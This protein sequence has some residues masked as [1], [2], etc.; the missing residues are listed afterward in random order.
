MAE[1]STY[2]Q[3]LF[4][5]LIYNEEGQP[6]E[7]TFIG[8]EPNYIILDGDFKRHVAAE[9]VDRQVINWL[10]EQATANKDLVSAG[11]MTMLGKDDLFT[12]A[13]IDSSLNQMDRVMEQGLP[14]EAR[15]MLG[16]LGF[17]IIVNTHGEVV[18][19][20]MPGQEVDEE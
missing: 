14:D 13:M 15:T 11:M 9:E 19:I 20:D 16:M 4:T 3:A 2:R 8:S 10:Q 5:G 17:K 1:Q 7:T 6:V 12:K 18:K